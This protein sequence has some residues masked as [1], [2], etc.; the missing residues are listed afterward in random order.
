MII[1]NNVLCTF[2]GV[3]LLGIGTG[4]EMV[5]VSDPHSLSV[6]KLLDEYESGFNSKSGSRSK[7]RPNASIQCCGSGTASIR[8]ILQYQDFDSRLQNWHLINLFFK[9]IMLINLYT[10]LLTFQF[11]Y[12]F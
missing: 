10:S 6:S 2:Y 8:I 11:I 9:K 12:K 3:G 4:S 1:F 7:S 5:S